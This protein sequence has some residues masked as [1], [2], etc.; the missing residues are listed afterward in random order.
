VT[1]GVPVLGGYHEVKMRH[2]PIGNRHKLIAI[3]HGQC[4][5][6]HEIVLQINKYQTS[7]RVFSH[8]RI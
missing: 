2:Q 7:H 3:S 8:K 1:S 4:A 6:R 5:A